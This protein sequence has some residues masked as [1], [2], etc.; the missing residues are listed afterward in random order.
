MSAR[1]GNE[2][3]LKICST[4]CGQDTLVQLKDDDSG[5]A[6]HDDGTVS[7]RA[8][9]SARLR[10]FMSTLRFGSVRNND[11][12]SI[13]SGEFVRE[14]QFSCNLLRLNAFYMQIVVSRL[15]VAGCGNGMRRFLWPERESYL[16]FLMSLFFMI[17]ALHAVVQDAPLDAVKFEYLWP[18]VTC[19]AEI[20]TM[21]RINLFLK[22]E[23]RWKMLT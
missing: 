15:N 11:W 8:A 20:F 14:K 21:S 13:I 22:A 1:D 10:R 2:N 5:V 17:D 9:V 19:E 3:R 18:T 12:M 6:R 16:W 23:N 4:L 7:V